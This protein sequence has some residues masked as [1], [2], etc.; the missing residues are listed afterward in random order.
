MLKNQS[1][2]LKIWLPVLITGAILVLISIMSAMAQRDMMMEDRKN[3]IQ[4]LTN[5]AMGI[6]QHLHGR[7]LAGLMTREEAQQQARDTIREMTYDNGNYI[8]GYQRDGTMMIYNA[9]PE[10]E[11]S[12][13]LHLKD[14]NGVQVIKE[15]ADGTANG[16]STFLSYVWPKPGTDGTVDKISYFAGFAPWDWFLG[17]GI[18]LDDVDAAFTAVLWQTMALA[19]LGLAISLGVAWAV[20]RS[21][22]GPLSHMEEVMECMAAGDL[23]K[24]CEVDDRKD[25]IGTMIRA[26]DVFH[27]AMKENQSTEALR[28]DDERMAAEKAKQKML[29]LANSF[30]SSVGGLVSNLGQAANDLSQ[31]SST[32]S[33]AAQQSSDRAQEVAGATE[34]AST[35]V[36]TVASAA[37]E[38]S[39]SITT[40]GDQVHRAA[41]VTSRAVEEARRTNSEMGALVD[42]SNRIS[43]VVAM[44]TDIADQTNLLAL[45]A[46][47]E[48]ARAGE[49]GKGFAVVAHEVKN[50]ANQTSKATEDISRQIIAV[51]EQTRK[52]GAS[53]EDIAQIVEEI[54]TIA[55]EVTHSVQEQAA[56]TQEISRGIQE[57]SMG[58]SLVASTIG[59]VQSA[60]AET[61]RTSM[62]VEQAAGNLNGTAGE[63]TSRV[64]EFLQTV[65]SA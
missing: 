57:A 32:M 23:T 21:I 2:V 54:S 64:S 15:G 43:E 30:E 27:G 60:A 24:H 52:N 19:L 29:D 5:V 18:Y 56:A 41:D 9:A 26:L 45:N 4:G 6:V 51:Q 8:F 1:I 22:M 49:A 38:L 39:S 61:G 53:I 11:G 36:Q 58:T 31:A 59:E 63:L 25:E 47:I 62:T 12:N 55:N 37:E 42:A 40:I 46:T 28:R 65:R 35:N 16:Q 13:L 50:L 33:S 17:T 44:I 20:I 34:T 7:E 48:A 10:K 3:K 14:E